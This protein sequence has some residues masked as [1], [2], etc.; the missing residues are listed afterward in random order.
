MPWSLWRGEWVTKCC[1]VWG[2]SCPQQ[3]RHTLWIGSLPLSRKLALLPASTPTGE[4]TSRQLFVSGCLWVLVFSGLLFLLWKEVNGWNV[5]RV[6]FLLWKEV[7]RWNVLR[8]GFYYE[9]RWKSEMFWGDGFYYEKRW[10]GEMFWIWVYVFTM[11]RGH[12]L[13]SLAAFLDVPVTE[14][15]W[16]RG[17]EEN[18]VSGNSLFWFVRSPKKRK[19]KTHLLTHMLTHLLTHLPVPPFS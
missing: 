5:L 11:K 4:A 12:L 8:Y 2:G 6:W 17:E 3:K 1:N 10:M 16:W 19:K 13:A 9:K 14:P 18:A 7:N 15:G